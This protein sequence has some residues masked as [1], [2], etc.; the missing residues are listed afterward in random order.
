MRDF[1]VLVSLP[2]APVLLVVSWR[3]LRRHNREDIP[4]GWRVRIAFVG[5]AS[6]LLAYLIPWTVIAYHYILLNSGR[7][8]SGN[9][10][11]DGVL[12][13]KV[14]LCLAALSFILGAFGPKSSRVCLML[15]AICIGFLWLSI[16]I[17]IL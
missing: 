2:L 11:I 1:L 14:S 8:V 4:P 10:L 6:G 16:P 13:L 12:A 5:L 3:T 7:P 15:S 9:E 17:G